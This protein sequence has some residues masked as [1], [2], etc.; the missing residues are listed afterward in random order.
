MCLIFPPFLKLPGPFFWPTFNYDLCLRK[1]FYRMFSLSM[2]VAKETILPSTEWKERHR[3]CDSNVD[4]NI[5]CKRFISEFARCCTIPGKN[6]SRIPKGAVI[7]NLYSFINSITV[8][9]A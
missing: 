3:G 8:H 5:S 9:H 4:P 2:Q 6:R 1:K 7:Y